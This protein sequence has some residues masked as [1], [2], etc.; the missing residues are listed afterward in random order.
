[1]S[2]GTCSLFRGISQDQIEEE[3][4]VDEAE[5]QFASKIAS[6]YGRSTHGVS[7]AQTFL[8]IKSFNCYRM[9]SLSK[10]LETNVVELS[11]TRSHI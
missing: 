2:Y 4:I 5:R 10:R 1:M 7:H 6:R 8:D 11:V 3:A 9:L